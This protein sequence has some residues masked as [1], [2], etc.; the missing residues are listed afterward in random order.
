MSEVLEIVQGH[1]FISIHV[2]DCIIFPLSCSFVSYSLLIGRGSV[3]NTGPLFLISLF[4]SV[5]LTGGAW[6]TKRVAFT[7][8][9]QKS[10]KMAEN[11]LNELISMPNETQETLCDEV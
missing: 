4:P 1:H 9:Q 3:I 7:G 11:K 8:Q 5:I 6:L 10:E 2:A